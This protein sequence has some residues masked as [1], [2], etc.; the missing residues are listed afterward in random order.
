MGGWGT[1]NKNLQHHPCGTTQRV[2]LWEWT[3]FFSA[4]PFLHPAMLSLRTEKYLV[5]CE[6][7]QSHIVADVMLHPWLSAGANSEAPPPHRLLREQGL[8]QRIRG[9][10]GGR[11]LGGWGREG[12]QLEFP[13]WWTKGLV[14]SEKGGDKANRSGALVCL[15]AHRISK[16]TLSERSVDQEKDPLRVP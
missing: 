7:V 15:G 11:N 8:Q 1:G 12:G 3:N 9:F 10:R 6:S 14:F 2:T 5:G 13:T 16:D 4:A